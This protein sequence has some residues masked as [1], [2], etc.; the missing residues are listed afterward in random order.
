[1]KGSGLDT[2]WRVS[3]VG[4]SH[5]ETLLLNF[6]LIGITVKDQFKLHWLNIIKNAES[7]LTTR[8]ASTIVF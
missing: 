7:A 6:S 2:K 1:M 5:N 3:T 8:S 4:S